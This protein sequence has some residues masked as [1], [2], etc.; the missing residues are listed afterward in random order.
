MLGRLFL[1]AIQIVAGWAGTPWIERYVSL[2]GDAQVF[3]RAA[4]VAVIVWI[5]GLIGAQVLKDV[6]QPSPA[7]LTWTLVGALIGAAL[8]VFKVPQMFNLSLPAPPLAI[9]L[10]LAILGYHIKR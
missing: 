3:V 5:M 1:I 8:I 7:T 6:A 4:I 9:L 10:G 2:G